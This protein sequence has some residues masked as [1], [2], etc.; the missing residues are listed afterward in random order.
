LQVDDRARGRRGVEGGFQLLQAGLAL[1]PAS[2]TESP[3][4]RSRAARSPE[5]SRAWPRGSAAGG[6]NRRLARRI[7]SA[8]AP[9]RPKAAR[10]PLAALMNVAASGRTARRAGLDRTV[11]RPLTPV[12]WLKPS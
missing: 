10:S 1:A 11:A 6:V 8:V 3:S 7:S 5:R 9:I 12:A 4:G 2:A